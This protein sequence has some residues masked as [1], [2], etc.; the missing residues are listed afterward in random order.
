MNELGSL[1]KELRIGAKMSLKDV[2]KATGISDSKLNRI[3][4]GTNASE[5]G[6]SVLKALAKAYGICLVELYLSAGYLD[7]ED[8]TSYERAFQHVDLLT[9][10]EK[11]SIQTQI[12]LFTKGR[13]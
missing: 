7:S 10:D 9:E 12:D 8:V 2:Y 3:E 1:L 4:R 6:A 11:L 13:E 5:P